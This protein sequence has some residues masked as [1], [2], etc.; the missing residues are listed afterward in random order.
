M[1]RWLFI[2]IL[3]LGSAIEGRCQ[4]ESDYSQY[5]NHIITFNPGYTGASGMADLSA[6]VRRQWSGIKGA[7]GTMS[8]Q[9]QVPVNLRRAPG[10]LGIIL[11]NDEYAFNKNLNVNLLYAYHMRIASGQLGMGLGVGMFQRK[12]E[13][14]WIYPG[15]ATAGAGADVAVP[16]QN[17]SDA[18]FDAS[19]GLYYETENYYIGLSSL[20]LFEPEFAYMQTG[21]TLKRQYYVLCGYKREMGN[22]AWEFLPSVLWRTDGK[23]SFFSGNC[24]FEY[25][26]KFWCGVSYR[27]QDAVTGLVGI[28]LSTGL[29][30]GYAY[31]FPV[32]KLG[33]ISDGSHEF[34]VRYQFRIGRERN[35]YKYRSIRYL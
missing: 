20:H 2:G 6:L 17:A 24:R 27:Q 14:D 25:N 8:L 18:T 35:V 34:S 5:F 9:A 30:I 26:K 33:G 1:R 21:E 32:S 12:L 11:S 28:E 3:L 31:D 19:F 13:A 15:S 7:P 22:P 10:G 16:E 4:Q 29:R 23:M